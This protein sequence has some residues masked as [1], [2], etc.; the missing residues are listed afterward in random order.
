[1]TLFDSHCHF[2][3]GD[4]LPALFARAREAGLGGLL[5]VGGSPEAN[6]CALAAAS[7][8][9][10]FAFAACG[11]EPDEAA[12]LADPRDLDARMSALEATL[13]NKERPDG[14]APSERPDGRAP[15]RPIPFAIGEIGL[16]YSRGEDAAAV[17]D[18]ALNGMAGPAEGPAFHLGIPDLVRVESPEAPAPEDSSV[19]DPAGDLAEAAPVQPASLENMTDDE[20]RIRST[21]PNP[22]F[23][24]DAVPG[25]A[26]GVIT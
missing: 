18:S 23:R 19:P 10:G 1:M 16:D 17:P 15:P 5:A 12:A 14:R 22:F 11:F 2:E 4:D 7:A 24:K 3:P 26:P 25:P 13:L 9:P 8:A 6:A 21:I 20:R